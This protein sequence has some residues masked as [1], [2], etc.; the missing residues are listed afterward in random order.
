MKGGRAVII[1]AGT[2]FNFKL[3]SKGRLSVPTK[4]RERLGRDF[5]MVAVTVKGCKCITLY[6][7]SEFEKVYE[8]TQHG[9]ENQMYDTS[10][11]L[12][13]KTEEC[14]MD[15]QGRFT[16]NQRLKEMSL[17]SNDSEV[18]L[19][20]NGGSIEIWNNEEYINENALTVNISRLRAKLESF[21]IEN[22]IET[23]KGLGYKLL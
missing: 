8:K 21:G 12:L 4:W 11:E 22:A 16:L 7:T 20:G 6:P 10:K 5:Y 23:R 17:L 2:Y 3:D 15:S 13:S 9:T 18:I 1:F 19:E 14:T